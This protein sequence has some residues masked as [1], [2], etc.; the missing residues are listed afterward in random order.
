MREPLSDKIM[1][2]ER[3]PAVERDEGE[4]VEREVRLDGAQSPEAV[5]RERIAGGFYHTAAVAD[6]VARRIVKRGDL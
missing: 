2:S 3:E 4:P 5:N 6:V 1:R